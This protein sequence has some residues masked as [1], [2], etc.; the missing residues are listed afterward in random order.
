[1]KLQSPDEVLI[2]PSEGD[3]EWFETDGAVSLGRL[4]VRLPHLR[5]NMYVLDDSFSLRKR[6][7][8]TTIL[9]IAGYKH[10]YLFSFWPLK[11][12]KVKTS[13]VMETSKFLTVINL[14]GKD[15]IVK[16]EE[17]RNGHKAHRP[18]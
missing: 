4:A 9:D 17:H 2:Q 1:M 6:G 12:L 7:P 5:R 3:M 13:K 10:G 11:I 15:I 14:F 18:F 16:E 8:M